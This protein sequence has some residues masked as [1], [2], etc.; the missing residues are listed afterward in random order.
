MPCTAMKSSLRGTGRAC[1]DPLPLERR[2]G[3]HRAA[4]QRRDLQ[5]HDGDD[6]DQRVAE[7]VLAHDP[8]FGHAAGAGRLDVVRPQ[9]LQQVHPDQPEEHPAGQQAQGDRRQDGVPEDVEM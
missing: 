9:R 8:A 2:L 3:Q 6:R 7:G 4:E 1:T 5:A